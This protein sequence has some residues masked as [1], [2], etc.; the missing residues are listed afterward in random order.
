MK[1][2]SLWFALFSCA[3]LASL[4]PESC[5]KKDGALNLQSMSNP[6]STAVRKPSPPPPPPPAAAD[7]AIAYINNSNLMVMN[8]DGSNQTIIATADNAYSIKYPS[9]SPDAHSIV[10]C[11][12]IG[13]LRGM[14]IVGVSVV[15]GKP[16]GSSLHQ[17]TINQTGYPA[18]MKWSPVGDLIVFIGGAYP[19]ADDPNIYRITSTGGDPR[20]VYTAATTGPP[21][22]TSAFCE[23]PT[24]SPDATKLAFLEVSDGINAPR[25][26]N[27][28]DLGTRTVT[29]VVLLGTSS[30]TAV[31]IAW[32]RNGGRIAYGFSSSSI[33]Y[34]IYTVTPTSHVTPL[35]L[36]AGYYPTWSPDDSKLAYWAPALQGNKAG[37][38]S[39][40][41]ATATTTATRQR[42][43]DGTMPD[44]RMF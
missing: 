32:S 34:A 9:W 26:L 13:G 38:Y 5:T 15:S 27:V 8:A 10:F 21:S 29:P 25:N 19:G 33:G 31:G 7:P 44:W 40:T 17:V 20:I 24:W 37:I 14:W 6:S 3:V 4:L 11:G 1:Q 23:W 43:A 41:F 18:W 35:Y 39:Y 42:L 28:F 30:G 12:T 22:P 16:T 36:F 2:L